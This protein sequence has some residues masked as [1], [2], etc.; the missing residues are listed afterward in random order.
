MDILLCLKLA[1]T[2]SA[3]FLALEDCE[4]RVASAN[5]TCILILLKYNSVSFNIDFNRVGAAYIHLGAHLLRDNYASKL[6]N[7]TYNTCGFQ[8]FLYLSFLEHL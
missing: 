1:D 6:V 8:F 2:F 4:I 5:H 3:Y 7:V